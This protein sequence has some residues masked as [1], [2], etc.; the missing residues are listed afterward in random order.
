MPLTFES[1]DKNGLVTTSK[2]GLASFFKLSI[3]V[4]KDHGFLF[5]GIILKCF[6]HL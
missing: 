2:K 1:Q 4:K 6:F 3:V 5:D